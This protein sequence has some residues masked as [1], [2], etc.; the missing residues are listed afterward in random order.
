MRMLSRRAAV[1]FTGEATWV[2]P[3]S[4]LGCAGT[5]CPAGLIGVDLPL[6]LVLGQL[7]QCKRDPW[8]IESL[9]INQIPRLPRC[10]KFRFVLAQTGVTEP[11]LEV[12]K[13]MMHGP[14]LD[15]GFFVLPESRHRGHAEIEALESQVPAAEE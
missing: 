9:A 13:E 15:G 8:K 3:C 14:F 11:G 4:S 5:P 10:R 7:V 12:L 2:I 1:F 6:C